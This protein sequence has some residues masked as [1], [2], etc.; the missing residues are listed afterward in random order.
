[1]GNPVIDSLL[2]QRTHQEEFIENLLNRVAEENR[3]LVEAEVSNLN[4][5]KERITQIDA[6]LEPL[7]EFEKV[8]GAH[9]ENTQTVRATGRRDED[10]AEPSG[11]LSITT[12]EVKYPTAGHFMVDYVRTLSYRGDDGHEVNPDRD[13]VQ[14]VAVAMGR[15]AGDVP[16]GDHITT[17]DIPS[18]LPRPIIGPLLDD[19][20][21]ARPFLASVGI[22]ELTSIQGKTF[23]RPFISE[24]TVAGEQAAEKAELVSGELKTDSVQ[25]DKKT[26][27]GWVNISRQTL[28]WSSPAAWNIIIGD[29][30]KAYGVVTED[31]AAEDFE[32]SITQTVTVATDDIEG[33]VAALY[34]AA[35]QAA[36]ANGTKRASAL[37]MPNHIWTS[38]DMW[39]VLG[40]LLTIH[41]A[42]HVNSVGSASPVGFGGDLLSIT[43]TMVPGLP[44]GTMIVGNPA[45]Y[46][47][48]EARVGV[49]Q[50]VEPRRLGLEVAYGG[51]A[52][53]GALDASRFVKITAP[54]GG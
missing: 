13:A 26:F 49:L 54:T 35:V 25:F 10:Q 11:R 43:R 7:E 38:I 24:H 48:Y 50:A 21:A 44:A 31:T 4:S 1:M 12:R 46:E 19:L 32:D 30:Q 18:L 33:Y 20:D 8:R 53:Y 5:A 2:E 51:Y 9:R 39:A 6:Q 41:R 42:Q 28:D 17:S 34:E 23:D 3:D 15:A 27:G 14:R 45:G 52:A 47:Y 29:L 36:T 22:R 16:P 37:R 40:E